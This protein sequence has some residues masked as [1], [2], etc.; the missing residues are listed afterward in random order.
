M[1][2]KTTVYLPDQLKSAVERESVRLGW[3]EAEVIRSAVAAFVEAPSPTIG[4]LDAE[5]IAERADE[6][7]A[8][9]G[10]R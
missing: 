3:S 8:G 4:F 5:P 10:E 2:R 1:T 6:L 9:F 7:L